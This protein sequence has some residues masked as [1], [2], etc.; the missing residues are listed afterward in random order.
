MSQRRKDQG[1]QPRQSFGLE[2]KGT[3]RAAR[4]SAMKKNRKNL[5]DE[6][7][8]LSHSMHTKVITAVVANSLSD[9]LDCSPPGSSVHEIPQARILEWVATPSSRGPSQPRNR[10]HV[11]Y[12]SCVGGG[13]FTTSATWEPLSATA[14][15]LNPC[16]KTVPQAS[17]ASRQGYQP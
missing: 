13:F 1:R 3:K 4:L 10:T 15:S 14:K 16:L 6:R 5:R 8:A 17:P 2:A 7:V 9:S 12:I 11:S